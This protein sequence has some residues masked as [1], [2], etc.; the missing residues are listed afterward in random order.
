MEKIVQKA[1]LPYVWDINGED[2][3]I[4]D[5]TVPDQLRTKLDIKKDISRNVG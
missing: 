5:E 2:Y 4:M 1:N 3:W